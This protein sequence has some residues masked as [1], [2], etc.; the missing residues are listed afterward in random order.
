VRP[1]ATLTALHVHPAA[2][3]RGVGI[4]LRDAVMAQALAWD[5]RRLW[6]TVVQGNSRA[7]AFHERRGWQGNGRCDD[8]AIAGHRVD[9]VR[10]ARDAQT[11]GRGRRTALSTPPDS[12]VSSEQGT[13]ST[14]SRTAPPTAGSPPRVVEQGPPLSSADSGAPGEEE[15][16][17][18]LI[19]RAHDTAR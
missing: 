16:H 13:P 7:R 8:H 5:R 12:R 6:L 9:T 2:Y 17:E 18:R 15:P 10:Y 4:M 3:G 14:P 1:W 19:D 11:K